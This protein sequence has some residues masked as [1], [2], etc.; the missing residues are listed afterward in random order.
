MPGR[1]GLLADVGGLRRD[2]PDLRPGGG[3]MSFE[4]WRFLAGAG[5]VGAAVFALSSVLVIARVA[6]GLARWTSRG[7]AV[8]HYFAVVLGVGACLALGSW[9]LS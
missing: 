7:A 3:Q 2:P 6:L 9:G 1:D 8:S 5:S 4:L